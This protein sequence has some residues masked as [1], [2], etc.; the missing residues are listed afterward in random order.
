MRT[1][2]NLAAILM[3]GT[4]FATP[5]LAAPV[6]KCKGKQGETIYQNLPC[7]NG[8]KPV[9]K[10]E[11]AP[12][13][14]SPDQ[15][16]AAARAAN[17]IRERQAAAADNAIVGTST[18]APSQAGSPSA[19]QCSAGKRIWI[20]Q[21][22]CPATSTRSVADSYHV[23]GTLVTTGEHVSG[24]ATG[25]HREVVPVQSQSLNK[26]DA[27]TSLGKGARTTE[28]GRGG[29]SA[30]ERNKMRGSLNCR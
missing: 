29:D 17:E 1:T 26:N 8:T 19:Y 6:Y 28:H 12:A 7:P 27:C 4:L 16:Y 18:T 23:E 14:D 20:Q 22:P 15:Y 5:I 21:T 11:Y 9:A 2:S 3:A 24:T 10:G 13:P 30:Y 25:A